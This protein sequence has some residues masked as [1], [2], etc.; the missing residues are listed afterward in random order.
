M[1]HLNM[2][3][4]SFAR[5]LLKAGARLMPAHVA[6]NAPGT[7]LLGEVFR[8]RDVVQ[9]FIGLRCM[10]NQSER[11]E[12]EARVMARAQEALRAPSTVLR[13]DLRIADVLHAL[14]RAIES[15]QQTADQL[16]DAGDYNAEFFASDADSLRHA[17]HYL[18]TVEGEVSDVAT[19]P[20]VPI[21]EI[22]FVGPPRRQEWDLRSGSHCPF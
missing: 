7:D 1:L 8:L 16:H 5:M 21:I 3:R 20:A 15:N 9:Q 6:P 22:N 17:W 14:E 18:R 13:G 2:L 10:Q 12:I 4:S 11:Q 19:L